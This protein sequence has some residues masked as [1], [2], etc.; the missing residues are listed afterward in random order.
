MT[1][2]QPLVTYENVLAAIFLVLALVFPVLFH[3]VHLGATFLPMFFPIALCGLLISPIP[4]MIVGF[5]APLLSALLTGMPPLYP[6]MA[7]LMAVE[8]VVLAGGISYLR[9]R[10]DWG[11]YASLISGI[12]AQRIILVATVLVIAPLFHL[13]GKLSSAGLIISGISGVILQLLILPPLAMKLEPRI[14]N[15]QEIV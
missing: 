5:L 10:R 2:K 8:G 14:K 7:P 6:P 1:S 3:V 12:V 9:L 13:P 15:L 4:A 11:I